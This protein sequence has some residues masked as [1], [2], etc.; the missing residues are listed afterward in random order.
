MGF[1]SV[2]LYHA[3]AV[4]NLPFIFRD[5]LLPNSYFGVK[6]IAEYYKEVINDEGKQAILL[7]VPLKDLEVMGIKMV[8]DYPG[9]EE[10]LTFTLKMREEEVWDEWGQLN[11]DDKN[12]KNCLNLIGSLKV[13]SAVMPELLILHN[14][15]LYESVKKLIDNTDNSYSVKGIKNKSI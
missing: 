13:E 10:P 11:E 4:E 7:E 9:L 6:K 2:T 1:K 8:P 3:T 15:S 5:G 12:Y 14:R